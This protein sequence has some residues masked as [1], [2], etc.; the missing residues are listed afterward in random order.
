MGDLPSAVDL[1]YQIALARSPSP[2]E[3]KNALAY[4]QNEAARLNELSWLLFNLDEFI[5]VK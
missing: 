5:Y 2:A 3:R 4:L 1:A